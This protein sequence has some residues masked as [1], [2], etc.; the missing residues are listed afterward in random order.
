MGLRKR[1]RGLLEMI[2]DWNNGRGKGQI[3]DAKSLAHYLAAMGTKPPKRAKLVPPVVHLRVT[4][5]S[6]TP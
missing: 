3:K 6:D 2:E 4:K 5:V 1:Q